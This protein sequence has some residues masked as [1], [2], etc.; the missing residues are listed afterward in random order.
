[1]R[2]NLSRKPMIDPSVSSLVSASSMC[3]WL[4]RSLSGASL[5]ASIWLDTQNNQRLG[6]IDHQN[7]IYK[8]YMKSL[9]PSWHF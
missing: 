5:F 9:S 6:E 2:E 1:M 4:L 8:H 3:L 7:V